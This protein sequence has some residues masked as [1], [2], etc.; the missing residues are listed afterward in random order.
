[1]DKALKIK[2]TLIFILLLIAIFN[3]EQIFIKNTDAIHSYGNIKFMVATICFGVIA[4]TS[5]YNFALYSYMRSRQHL[6]YALAQLFTLVFLINLD[7]LFIKPFDEVF[8]LKS[9][10]LFDISQVLMLFFSLLFIKEFLRTYHGDKLHELINIILYI[11]IFDFV[12][13][14][15]FSHTIVTKF[16]PIFIP[17]WLVLSEARRLI[18]DKDVP[19]Y[20]LLF[21]WGFVLFVVAVEYIGFVQFTGIVFPFLHVALAL[22]SI[23][24]SLAISYKFKLLEDDRRIQQTLLLQ[25]SRL[26]SMG[27]MISIVAHQW[28][29]PLNFLS[30]SLMNIKKNTKGAEQTIKEASN[31][32]QYMSKTIENFRNFYNPSKEKGEFDIKSACENAVKIANISVQINELN[33]FT[34]YGNKNEFEQVILNIVNNAREAKKD[35]KIEIIIDKATITICDNA[36]G[37]DKKNIDKI[38]EPYFST[39]KESDGIGLYIAKT[40]VEREMGGKLS[41][42]NKNGGA[43]FMIT[44]PYKKAI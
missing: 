2:L 37:I 39:K 5:I 17:I 3:Y 11:A 15:I 23:I 7:S 35:A 10:F 44:L 6:Y 43:V 14:L 28:R 31:Q 21:G 12:F 36:G 30:F 27:E 16:I 18:K 29:Q 20:Y 40:I 26:A 9:L 24:L 34:F 32:L 25:Q 13:A 8:G 33:P 19:F 41:V 1:M 4:S 38:F 42:E 22:D